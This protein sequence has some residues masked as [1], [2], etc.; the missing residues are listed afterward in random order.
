MDQVIPKTTLG[1]TFGK[2]MKN[3]KD[4]FKLLDAS[5]DQQSPTTLKAVVH[6]PDGFALCV[7]VQYHDDVD[8]A[9]LE[10]ARGGGDPILLELVINMWLAYDMG[11]GMLPEFCHGQILPR[12]TGLRPSVPEIV[13]PT[14]NLDGGGQKRKRDQM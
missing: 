5:I 1:V 14:L 3:I 7:N 2:T 4:F 11:E 8:S 9:M 10:L 6:H 13:V 12:V